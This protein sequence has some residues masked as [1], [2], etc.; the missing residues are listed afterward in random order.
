[1]EIK[2]Q[3]SGKIYQATISWLLANVKVNNLETITS[4]KEHMSDRG[5]KDLKDKYSIHEQEKLENLKKH[6]DE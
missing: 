3:F 5:L 1:M 4:F 6:L 2:K